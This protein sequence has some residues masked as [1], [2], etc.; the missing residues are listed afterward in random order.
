MQVPA[1]CWECHDGADKAF[2]GA[3]RHYPV[4]AGKQCL[5]C[6]SPHRSPAEKMLSRATPALC[7]DCHDKGMVEKKYQHPPAMEN[8]AICHV[9]HSGENGKLLNTDLEKLCLQCHAKATETHLHGMGK[10]PYVDAVTGQL[11]NCVSCH[12]PHGSDFEKL[13]HADRKQKLCQRCHKRGQHEL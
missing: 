1:L 5:N 8:C 7:F 11:I 12:N 6:H 13:T 10:S 3:Q 2:S 9:A 4:F